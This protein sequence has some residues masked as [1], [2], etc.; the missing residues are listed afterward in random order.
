M[1]RYKSVKMTK[2]ECKK[3][4]VSYGTGFK[5]V[6]IKKKKKPSQNA[7]KG[8]PKTPVKETSRQKIKRL[9]AQVKRLKTKKKVE[10]HNHYTASQPLSAEDIL[11][12]GKVGGPS[13]LH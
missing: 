6:A 2:A 13:G 5:L 9:E 4:G 1:P 3:F 7:T 8:K 10:I 12:W 11:A